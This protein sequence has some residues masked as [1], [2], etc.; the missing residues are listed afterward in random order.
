MALPSA[1]ASIS[2]NQVNVELGLSGT[3]TISLNDAAVRDLFGVPSGQ[4]SMS[5]GYGK[6]SF[7]KAS[8][9]KGFHNG[10][11]FPVSASFGTSDKVTYSSEAVAASPSSNLPTGKYY[12]VGAGNSVKAFTVT[13]QTSGSATATADRTT[14]STDA[15]AA[16]PGANYPQARQYASGAGNSEKGFGYGGTSPTYTATADKTTYSTETSAASPS[17]SMSGA[18]IGMGCIGIPGKGFVSGG[19]SP[20]VPNAQVLADRTTY[21]TDTTASVPGANLPL[22]ARFM[23]VSG[24]LDK[25]FFLGGFSTTTSQK[26]TFST[27]TSAAVPGA[28]LPAAKGEGAGS[29]ETTKGFAGGG[30][31]GQSSFVRVTYSTEAT[32]SIPSTL[33][34]GRQGN[35]AI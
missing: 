26:T 24:N 15:T 16:V 17:A 20:T 9:T 19:Q 11:A 32:A 4:I 27:E 31:G 34:Q 21:S 35:T 2:L 18:R 3:A 30:Q 10:G 33:S 28:N 29:G 12:A 23:P 7:W 5:S 22:N 25:G 14:Y 13:G 8:L 1:P 6:A